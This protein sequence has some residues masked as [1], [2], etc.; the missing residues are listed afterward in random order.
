ME[1]TLTR[2]IDPGFGKFTGKVVAAWLIDHDGPD[3]TMKLIEDFDYTDP[4]GIRWPAPKGR[5]ID[6][7]SIPAVFWGPLIGS[8]YTGDFR[9]ASVVHDVAC[10]DKPYTSDKAHRML[11]NAMR[12]DG[13][14][15]WLA[16]Q[17]YTA[18]MLFGDQWGNKQRPL[19][20][21]DENL[22]LYQKLAYSPAMCASLDKLDATIA[23]TRARLSA[24]PRV[25]KV[26]LAR[27]RSRQS[28]KR[29]P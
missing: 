29:K 14:A 12:C 15:A 7:A 27:R 16:N 1:K 17:I 5:K 19:P 8:P 6:G 24:S 13:T 18:V 26:A 23:R 25:S 20:L 2:K 3:R 21:T 11:Y 4:E 28:R 22:R 9:R 10:E